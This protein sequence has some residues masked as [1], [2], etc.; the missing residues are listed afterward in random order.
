[1]NMTGGR[2]NEVTSD[3]VAVQGA[4]VMLEVGFQSTGEGVWFGELAHH[5]SHCRGVVR[6]LSLQKLNRGV[7]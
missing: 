6:L 5:F 1:M 3:L 7:S 2:G 4:E